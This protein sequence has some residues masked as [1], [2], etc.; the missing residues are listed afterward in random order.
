VEC[1]VNLRERGAH[2]VA[3]VDPADEDGDDEDDR[4]HEDCAQDD[5]ERAKTRTLWLRLR[6]FRRHFVVAGKKARLFA[7]S[8]GFWI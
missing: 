1:A 2:G 6:G 5:A 8:G 3:K 7:W 4:Q